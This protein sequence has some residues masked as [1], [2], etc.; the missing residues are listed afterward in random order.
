MAVSS[1]PVSQIQPSA[2]RIESSH[3]VDHL[4]PLR[5]TISP[6]GSG[7]Y[8]LKRFSY[9]AELPTEESF[10]TRPRPRSILRSASFSMGFGFKD[11]ERG[12]EKGKEKEK[13]HSRTPSTLSTASSG[14]TPSPP[15]IQRPTTSQGLF[16]SLHK[17]KGMKKKRSM[18]SLLETASQGVAGPSAIPAYRSRSSDAAST[19]SAI[20]DTSKGKRSSPEYQRLEEYRQMAVNHNPQTLPPKPI[21]SKQKTIWAKRH[22]M[23]VHTDTGACYMQAYDSVSLENDRQ[24][25]LLL[26]RLNPVEGPAFRDYTGKEPAQVLDLGCGPGHWMMEAV[27]CWKRVRVTGVDMVDILLPEAQDHDQIDFVQGNFLVFPWPFRNG[28]FDLVRMANLTLCIPYD[29]WEAII[30]EAHRILHVNGRLEFIDDEILFPYA[31]PPASRPAS[32]SSVTITKLPPSSTLNR[33]FSHLDEDEAEDDNDD[34]DSV[35]TE[36]TLVSDGGS[37]SPSQRQSRRQSST[38]TATSI[39]DSRNVIGAQPHVP[40][41]SGDDLPKSPNSTITIKPVVDTAS[42]SLSDWTSEAAASKDMETVYRNMLHK[43]FGVHSQPA[44]FVPDIM[45]HVFGNGGELMSYDLRLAPKGTE[46]EFEKSTSDLVGLGIVEQ[47]AENTSIEARKTSRGKAWFASDPDRE[48]KKR[49]KKVSK[50]PTPSLS[51]GAATS[52]PGLDFLIPEG[53]SAKAAGRLGIIAPQVEIPKTVSQIP[54]N[55]SA[56]AA[57]RLGIPMSSERSTDVPSRLSTFTPDDSSSDLDFD[58]T[59]SPSRSPSPIP[60]QAVISESSSS[61]PVSISSSSTPP[62]NRAS[63]EN[64]SSSPGDSKLSAKAAHRLG[65]SYSAL[66]EAAASAKASTRRPV[67]SS[68]TLVSSLIPLQSPGL[69]VWPNQFI[70]M[71]PTELEMHATKNV[72]TLINCKPTLA[73]F[74]GSFL[75]E[76][77]NRLESQE[78]FDEALWAYEAFRRRRFNW[79]D[80]LPSDWD[81]DPDTNAPDSSAPSTTKSGFAET[82]T[83]KSATLR[84]SMILDTPV[85]TSLDNASRPPYKPDELTQVRTIRVFEAFKTGEYTLA[86]MKTP[87]SPPPSPPR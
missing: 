9:I 5:Q 80:Y 15:A 20:S 74:V 30:A 21:R 83:A 17:S 79:P 42:S 10:V 26:R 50:P 69:I 6:Q 87:R 18:S 48:E 31:L 71:A 54:E 68:S 84:N 2:S 72:H 16:S 49:R 39:S 51:N 7:H 57:T 66:G 24:S 27:N 22:K 55:V 78:D 34:L 86:T 32:I 44:K 11:K 28:Q 38:S 77:G 67:S 53:L 43:K 12:K 76:D 59:P 64:L 29:K 33:G 37:P 63:T 3:S 75:D 46:K 25:D 8:T 61:P 81:T 14:A 65:I 70:P 62:G 4:R 41:S 36:S 52:T 13:G 85:S 56:K 35:E 1:R 82:S 19:L 23:K 60:P 58:S 73:E 40:Q 45:Q 47:K